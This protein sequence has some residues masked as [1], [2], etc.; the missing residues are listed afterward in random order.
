[1]LRS[2]SLQQRFDLSD[3]QAKDMLYDSASMRR[4]ARIDLLHDTEPV[5]TTIRKVR[6]LLEACQLTAR[7]FDAVKALFEERKLLQKAGTSV[8]ATRIGAA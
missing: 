3:P 5:E 2:C 4:F 8:D 1:M 6:H 7:M